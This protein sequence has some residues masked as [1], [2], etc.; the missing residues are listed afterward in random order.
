V[1]RFRNPMKN[2]LK[3]ENKAVFETISNTD[4][5]FL[6]FHIDKARKSQYIMIN[7]CI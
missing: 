6:N 3:T 2:K 1:D 7:N 4:A 5:N